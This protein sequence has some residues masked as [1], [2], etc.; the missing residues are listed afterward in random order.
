MLLLKARVWEKLH[1]EISVALG[2]VTVR[3]ENPHPQELVKV[4]H[5]EHINKG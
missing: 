4:N 3:L 5:A 2:Q 1:K